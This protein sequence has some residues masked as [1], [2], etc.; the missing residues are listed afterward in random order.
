MTAIIPQAREVELRQAWNEHERHDD[1][2]IPPECQ[3]GQI[4]PNEDVWHEDTAGD[5]ESELHRLTIE[6]S[7]SFRV[8]A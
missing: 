3:L 4:I 6:G 7:V 5:F 2:D 8:N 1:N